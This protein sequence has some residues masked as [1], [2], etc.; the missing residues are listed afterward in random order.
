MSDDSV[1]KLVELIKRKA[2]EYLDLLTAATDAEFEKAFMSLLERA[3]AVLEK[4]KKN[5][6]DLGEDG[7]TRFWRRR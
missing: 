6:A 5:F 7:L 1:Y 3:V 2:P 4:D